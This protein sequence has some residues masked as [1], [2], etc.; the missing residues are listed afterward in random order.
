[1]TWT[2]MRMMKKKWLM[3]D[4]SWYSFLDFESD[5]AG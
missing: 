1:M 3:W 5:F 4:V 2:R